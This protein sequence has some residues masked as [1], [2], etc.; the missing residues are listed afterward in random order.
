MLKIRFLLLAALL[1]AVVPAMGQSARSEDN[2]IRNPEFKIP[3]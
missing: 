1:G 2:L 3:G